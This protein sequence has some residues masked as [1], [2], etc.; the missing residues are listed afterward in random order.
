MLIKIRTKEPVNKVSANYSHNKNDEM[1]LVKKKK[2]QKFL[3]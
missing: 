3:K 1:I 2:R